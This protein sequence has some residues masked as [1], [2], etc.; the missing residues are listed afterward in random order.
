MTESHGCPRRAVLAAG[1]AGAL[2][3]LAGCTTYGENTSSQGQ[4]APETTAAPLPT[5]GGPQPTG[6]A[7]PEGTKP[8]KGR[9]NPSPT[10]GE[11]QRGLAAV[12]DIPVGGGKVFASQKVVVTQPKKGTIKA[13]SAVCTHAG[14]TVN[15]VSGGTINCPCHG[16]QFNV[17]D[18][19]VAGGPAPAPLPS[20]KVNVEGGQI[21]LG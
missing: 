15:A 13:F 4:R 14:C 10:Q 17:A 5:Q 16:S 12:S 11:P 20:L 6:E 21:R 7:E 18:G 3:A 1:G 2:A 19:S 9:P 8:P